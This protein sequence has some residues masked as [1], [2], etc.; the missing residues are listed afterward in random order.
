[1]YRL[2]NTLLSC[3]LHVLVLAGLLLHNATPSSLT[4]QE[5]GVEPD[6]TVAESDSPTTEEAKTP[7][8][9]TPAIRLLPDSV[10]GL[11]RIPNVPDFC[12]AWRKTHLG[13]LI[14]DPAM[15]PF[16]EAQ[17]ERA[18][19]YFDVMDNRVGLKPDD[20]YHIATGEA[21]AAWLPFEKD[22]RRPFSM[23][24]LADIRGKR[25]EADDAIQKIDED[26]KA[27]GAT[28]NDTEHRGQTIRVYK[29]KQKPGQIKV[30]QIAITLDDTRIIAADRD[31]VVMDLLDGIAGESEITTI[32][33]L[34]E[35]RDV[36]TRSSRAIQGPFS[37]GG[38]TVAIEWFAH[39]FQMGRI[40]RNALEVDRGTRIDILKLLENQ[41]FDAVK[42]AGGIVAIAGSKYD[43]L[44]RGFVL[45]PPTTSEPSKYEKAARM[46][47]FVN[48]DLGEIPTWIDKGAATVGRIRLNIEAAFLASET[49]VNEAFDDEIFMQTIE[50]V[51]D[52]TS[53]PQIDIL[54]KVL[55]SLDH[56]IL[57]ITD[58][59]M[60]ADVSSERMLVAIRLND[61]EAIKKA[62]HNVMEVEPEAAEMTEIPGVE[63]WRMQ[64]GDSTE[65]FEEEI[66]GDLGFGDEEVLDEPAPLLDHFAIAMVGKAAGSQ[67]PYLMFSSHPE[68]L[69]ETI[70]R[71]VEGKQGGFASLA[72]VQEVTEALKELGADEVSIARIGRT[73]LS[74]RV[75]YELLRQGK[76]R[77]SDSILATLIRRV[78][79]EENQVDPAELNT[80]KLPPFATIEKHLPNGGN[81]MKTEKDG[82][83]IN[84][85]FLK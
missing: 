4:A 49:L 7:P 2:V 38:S 27:N 45:A 81:F 77:D 69:L 5:S 19:S 59:T 17:R 39:P 29:P 52:D 53:G 80:A 84:G 46:L 83:S 63:I 76:L 36:L 24:V 15:Q 10:A 61:A 64:R 6:A 33:E 1:M 26:L 21:V 75:K 11:V 78:F 8:K 37:Q 56:E 60:P 58:N 41:G 65:T 42:A 25:A 32:S 9:Y 48:E 16:I 54:N 55:P 79:E 51:R 13:D 47:S 28:R 12:V 23:V 22:K 82:W 40:V 44:H 43:L 68:L 20:L 72:D 30:E 62:V 18:K 50:G 73:K 70:Q 57:L 14:D 85:F 71:I 34:P 67:H 66:F 31:T 35:F 3:R 74:M